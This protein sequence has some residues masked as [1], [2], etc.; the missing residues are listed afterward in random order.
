MGKLSVNTAVFDM[1]G[2][3]EE[4]MNKFS[5]IHVNTALLL[6]SKTT[7]QL[8]AKGSLHVNMAKMLEVEEGCEVCTVNASM[9]IGP[10][11]AVPSGTTL[12]MVNG[13]L[14]VL[15][16]SEKAV[17]GYTSIHVNGSLVVPASIP[18]SR[19]FVNGQIITYP[20]GAVLM[21]SLVLNDSFI[22]TV[23]PG[24]LIFVKDVLRVL[25]ADPDP[26]QEKKVTIIA[27]RVLVREEFEE[28]LSPIV[29]DVKTWETVPV[30]HTYLQT[31]QLD[32][33]IVLQY[34]KKLYISGN[35]YLD[36]D[37]ASTLEALETLVVTGQAVVPEKLASVFKEKCTRMG[38]FT[39]YQGEL[40]RLREQVETLGSELLADMPEGVTVFLENA[41]LTVS[42]DLGNEELAGKI[43]AIHGW[44]SMLMLEKHQKVLL[45]KKIRG[46]IEV[47]VQEEKRC[48]EETGGAGEDSHINTAYYKL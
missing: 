18:G 31:V 38:S 3:T 25:D 24:T 41:Q 12:L 35:L 48:S 45:R 4:G 15:P 8:L 27:S 30:G 40:W 13:E 23:Q 29:K 1:C 32:D 9:T 14:T 16:G 46:N 7:K 5:G 37:N 33:S 34:G 10:D 39:M 11:S 42:S 2:A 22:R 47:I 6:V 44:D 17:Q 20:D 36:A 43:H 28:V 26:L 19:F 21:D